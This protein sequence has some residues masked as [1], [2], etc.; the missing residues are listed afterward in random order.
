MK[1]CV[2]GLGKLGFPMATFLRSK[3]DVNGYDKNTKI[4]E[5]IRKKPN[6]YL[7]NESK[8]KKYLNKNIKMSNNIYDSLIN[9]DICFITV[10][11]PSLK[12]GKFSNKFL[13]VTNLPSED[14]SPQSVIH[15]LNV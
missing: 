9:T 3:F 8:I 4:R 7:A 15:S 14:I 5:I 10:P 6:L 1:I 12:N 13:L 11:T 2:I